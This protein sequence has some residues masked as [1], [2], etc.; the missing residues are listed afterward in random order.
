MA[1]QKDDVPNPTSPKHVPIAREDIVNFKVIVAI[2]FGT[3]GT[4]LGYAL[5]G[6]DEK[7]HKIH[8]AQDW[9]KNPDH[10]NKTDILLTSQGKFLAFGDKALQIYMQTDE[11]DDSDEDGDDDD[12]DDDDDDSDDEDKKREKMRIKP[13]LFESIKMAFYEKKPDGSEGD[14][15]GKIACVDGRLKDTSLVFISALKFMKDKIFNTFN[16]HHVK[17]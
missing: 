16:K 1:E 5:V 2:D 10:K 8:T 17:V 15:R 14:N 7:D 3:H 6:D 12:D 13:M 11:D 9:C 4:A